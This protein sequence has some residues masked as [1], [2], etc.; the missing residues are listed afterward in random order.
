MIDVGMGYV[1]AKTNPGRDTNIIFDGLRGIGPTGASMSAR[2]LDNAT[3]CSSCV[4]HIVNLTLRDIHLEVGGPWLCKDVDG[5]VVDDVSRFPEGSTCVPTGGDSL[6][7]DDV[8]IESAVKFDPYPVLWDSNSI[9]DSALMVVGIQPNNR[10]AVA[11]D[12]IRDWPCQDAP[13]DYCDT[14]HKLIECETSLHGDSYTRNL[15]APSHGK[16]PNGPPPAAVSL[17]EEVRAKV[18]LASNLSVATI[19][20]VDW[21]HAM[22]AVWSSGVLPRMGSACST[23]VRRPTSI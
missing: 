4:E 14:L 20:I 22:P 16:H 7:S 19:H 13:K 10:S 5:V 15:T 6:K 21:R 12:T 9:E 2:G 18:R 23:A 8:E 11:P 3:G 1:G 17:V